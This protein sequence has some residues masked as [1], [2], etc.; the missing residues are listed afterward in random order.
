MTHVCPFSSS[1]RTA[2]VTAPDIS[3]PLSR[4]KRA[5]PSVTTRPPRSSQRAPR[6]AAAS[7]DSTARK[8]SFPPTASR[9]A[10]AIAL[11]TGC[12][13]E[14]SAEAARYSNLFASIVVW[15]NATTLV[16]AGAPSVIVPVLSKM[17]CDAACAVS[18]G[19][20]PLMSTPKRAPRPVPTITAVGVARPSAHGHAMT[21]TVMAN[22]KENR[23]VPS[24]SVHAVGT[25]PAFA[26]ANHAIHVA[27]AV[28]TTNGTNLDETASAYAWMGAFDV[29]ASSMSR[30]TLANMESAP[31]SVATI[32]GDPPLVLTVPP[33]TKSP[34]RFE[35]GI[36]SPV[37]A[38]S[39]AETFAPNKTRPSA[40]NRAP[41]ATRST[42]PR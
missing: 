21:S 3:T 13:L 11:P 31:T 14:A 23:N 38:L 24:L 5:L 25:A 9:P 4:M 34:T 17:T 1:A 42:S 30:T 15:S 20:P 10:R 33:M 37:K 32:S 28:A 29:C 36:D 12:S 7:N 39:S 6:P 2:S 40:G 19:S 41:G 18:S 22:R 35:T 26:A 16:T 8:P 27:V